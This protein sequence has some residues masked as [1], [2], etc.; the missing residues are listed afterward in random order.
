MICPFISSLFSKKHRELKFSLCTGERFSFPIEKYLWYLGKNYDINHCTI[1][2]VAINVLIHICKD[3]F[4]KVAIKK[5]LKFFKV[6]GAYDVFPEE[7]R[8]NRSYF[9]TFVDKFLLIDACS[10]RVLC[11]HFIYII[12]TY[13]W[14]KSF[15]LTKHYFC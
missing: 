1:K 15:F 8:Y 9:L 3:N 11:S 4:Y 7:A 6:F 2:I 12:R 10:A 14:T 5:P 13:L